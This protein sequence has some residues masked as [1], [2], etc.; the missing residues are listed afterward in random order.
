MKLTKLNSNTIV[1]LNLGKYSVD[2]DRKVSNPQFTTKQFLKKYW[3]FDAVYEEVLIPGSLLRI[4]LTNTSRMIMVEVSP[5]AIH[6]KYNKFMHKNR[7]GFLKKIEA[8]FA[9]RKWSEINGFEFVELNDEDI[10]NISADLF[11]NKFNINL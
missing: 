9:K 6:T 2:W 10:K 7:S 1:N 4:D 11:L 5:D 8:D 3:E